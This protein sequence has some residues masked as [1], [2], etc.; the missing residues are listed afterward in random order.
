MTILCK[1]LQQSHSKVHCNGA[2][3]KRHMC[4]DIQIMAYFRPWLFTWNTRIP[5]QPW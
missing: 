1:C 5:G 2:S 4:I 3:E